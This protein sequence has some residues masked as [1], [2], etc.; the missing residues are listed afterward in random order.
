MTIEQMRAYLMSEYTGEKWKIKVRR[1]SDEQI[2]AI[3]KRLIS[4]KGR[5]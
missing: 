3:Y 4:R 5:R 1:M 2:V